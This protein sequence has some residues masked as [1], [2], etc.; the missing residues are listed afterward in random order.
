LNLL[1]DTHIAL[2]SV[3]KSSRLPEKARRL[4]ADEEHQVAVSVVSVWEIAVKHAKTADRPDGMA[5]SGA[6]ALD[7]FERAGFEILPI[8]AAHAAALDGLPPV[9]QDPFDRMIVTQALTTPLHL[10]TA[11]KVLGRYSETVILV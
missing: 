2:W 11:D 7:A 3:A 10:V 1:L 4:I 9:H 5:V 6:R 8:T